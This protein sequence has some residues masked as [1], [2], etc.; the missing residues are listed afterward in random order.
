[1]NAIE[2]AAFMSSLERERSN[3][4]PLFIV[5]NA[6]RELNVAAQISAARDQLTEAIEI[7]KA[8]NEL[9]KRTAFDL[10][11]DAPQ[12]TAGTENGTAQD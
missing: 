7:L 10:R 8:K 2:R 5:A 3:L 6:E 9:T 4:H 1:M 11:N 12:G